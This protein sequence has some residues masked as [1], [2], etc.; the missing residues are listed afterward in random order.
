MVRELAQ[1]RSVTNTNNGH[2]QSWGTTG[3]GLSTQNSMRAEPE[4]KVARKCGK[5][6]NVFIGTLCF[7]DD[8]DDDAELRVLSP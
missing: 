3:T 2:V 8:D 6:E 4:L 7:D 1:Y 5:C